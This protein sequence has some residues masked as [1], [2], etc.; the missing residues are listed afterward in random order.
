MKQVYH[1]EP[2]VAVASQFMDRRVS[3]GVFRHILEWCGVGENVLP[4]RFESL[5]CSRQVAEVL[6]AALIARYGQAEGRKAFR[7]LES[8]RL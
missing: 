6:K 1:L 3:R 8:A 2:S 7:D 5:D 4:D